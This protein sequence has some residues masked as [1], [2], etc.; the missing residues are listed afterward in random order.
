M[1]DWVPTTQDIRDGFAL[2][3]AK[4]MELMSPGW[5]EATQFGEAAFDRWFAQLPKPERV[6]WEGG[7]PEISDAEREVI[8]ARR[9][10]KRANE[11][12]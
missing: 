2:Y 9:E 12:S 3:Y 8:E 4:D 1:T 10:K 7:N 5:Y 11:Q 6:Y